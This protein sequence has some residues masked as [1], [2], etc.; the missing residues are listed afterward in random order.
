VKRRNA[1]QKGMGENNLSIAS[2]ILYYSLFSSRP[3][4]MMHGRI[5]QI[6]KESINRTSQSI[7]QPISTARRTTVVKYQL[8]I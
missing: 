3:A 5:E 2:E 8:V 4:Q 7:N 6:M 1:R